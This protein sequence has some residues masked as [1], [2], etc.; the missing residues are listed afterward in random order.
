VPER[1]Y[2][3]GDRVAAW[4]LASVSALAVAGEMVPAWPDWITGAICWTACIMLWH[5]VK[6]LQ[7]RV[8]A[9]LLAFGTAGVV[10]GTLAGHSGFFIRALTQNLPLVGMLIAVSFL[11]LIGAQPGPGGETLP[12][13]R[14]AL[15]RTLIGVHLF[16][17]VINYSAVAIFADRLSART[18]LTLDQ[19]AALSQSF[20]IGAVWSPF[21]GAMAVALTFAPG[22][23]LTRLMCIG[24]PLALLGLA[25]SWLTLSSSRYHHAREFAGYPLRPEALWLPSALVVSVL[26]IHELQPAWPVLAIITLTAPILTVLTL[27]VR[28]GGLTGAALRRVIDV[29]LPEMGGEM[30]LFM[31]AGVLSAGMAG[32]VAAFEIG[33]P[34]NHFGATEAGYTATAMTVAAWL[35]F[36]PVILGMVVG[37]WIAQLNPDPNLLAMSLLMPWAIGLTACPLGNTILAVHARYQ[38][39]TR[40][41]L[42]RNRVFSAQMLVLSLIVLQIYERV[43]VSLP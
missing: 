12:R 14:G 23:S 5:R 4:L 24:L 8:I 2:A 15:F 26:L 20:I 11:Q 22:A 9:L 21:Y 16:G 31:A 34:F 42:N 13:G 10:A 27:L 36:H 29:R 33:L 40:A 3:G 38:I 30:A 32:A 39:P 41:L 18:R 1:S 43:A 7:R 37:P 35:G 6:P 25:I 17:A 19:A 28:D